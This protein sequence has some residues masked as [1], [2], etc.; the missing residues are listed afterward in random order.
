MRGSIQH[1]VY[2]SGYCGL[3]QGGIHSWL[4]RL[5][6]CS[7]D[8]SN[9]ENKDFVVHFGSVFSVSQILMSVFCSADIDECFLFH[10]Y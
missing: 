6:L 5:K 9:K 1:E 3:V 8:L 4:G 10:R 2:T 7:I